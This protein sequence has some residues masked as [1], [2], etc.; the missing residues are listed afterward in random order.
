MSMSVGPVSGLHVL[1]IDDDAEVHQRLR[2]LLVKLGC[3]VSVAASGAE[4]L[5][6]ARRDR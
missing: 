5:G 6:I 3:R 4:G 1:V 2:R